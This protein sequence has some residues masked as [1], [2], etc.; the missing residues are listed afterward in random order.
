MAS[1]STS[2]RSVATGSSA[3]PMWNAAIMGVAIVAAFWLLV[4]SNRLSWPPRE[5]LAGATTLAGCLALAGPLV[6]LRRGEQE[7]GVGDLAWLASG[8]LLWV[9]NLVAAFHG[10]P[11]GWNWTNP[12]GTRSMGLTMLAIVLAGRFHTRGGAQWTWTNILG[13]SLA[14][15]WIGVGLSATESGRSLLIWP[16]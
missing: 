3:Q 11:R 2:S 16:R 8:F 7:R 4:A 6:E 13:W 5:L 12:V 10:A 15:F 1:K 14:V 9:F